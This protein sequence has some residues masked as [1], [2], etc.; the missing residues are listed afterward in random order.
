MASALEVAATAVTPPG[1]VYVRAT[2][3]AAGGEVLT[4]DP[5]VWDNQWIT[6]QAEADDV[7][8][9]FAADIA[10]VS[11]GNV[12]NAGA[13][14]SATAPVNAAVGGCLHIPAGTTR[15][16]YMR[17]FVKLTG[18]AI[19]LAHISLTATAAGRIRFY[20]SSGTRAL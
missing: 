15:E 8:V 3:A 14:S 9:K 4:L 19:F 7:F 18:E 1:D 12:I 10:S 11:G 20:R 17:D 5:A 2:T 6:I 13:L 16:F